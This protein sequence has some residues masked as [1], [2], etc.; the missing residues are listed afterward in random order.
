MRTHRC[1]KKQAEK[2]PI[3]EPNRAQLPPPPTTPTIPTHDKDFAVPTGTS[4]GTRRSMGGMSL[5]RSECLHYQ[6]QHTNPEGKKAAAKHEELYIGI[7]IIIEEH[8]ENI[9]NFRTP[10]ILPLSRTLLAVARGGTTSKCEA[11]TLRSLKLRKHCTYVTF[12]SHVIYLLFYR[13]SLT[14]ELVESFFSI[15]H[16]VY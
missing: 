13:P 12:L 9:N 14:L 8:S 16:I 11:I 7:M 15:R 4:S 10:W 3:W 6:H 1:R 2:R 5:S